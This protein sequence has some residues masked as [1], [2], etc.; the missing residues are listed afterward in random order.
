M[1]ARHNGTLVHPYT[2]SGSDRSC[3]LIRARIAPEDP[4]SQKMPI[5]VSDQH[6]GVVSGVT[7]LFGKFDGST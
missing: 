4:L 1:V 3:R 5:L 6:L 7:L 2:M